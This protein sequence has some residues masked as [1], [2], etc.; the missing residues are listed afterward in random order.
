M[1]GF[2]GFDGGNELMLASFRPVTDGDLE[3][4]Y[5]LY[6]STRL[7]EMSVTGWSDD[8]VEEFL[9]MQFR[10]QH[11][12]YMQNYKG[13]SFDIILADGIPAG[14]LY[15]HRGEEGIRV[16]DISI[17]PEFRR[18]GIGGDIL[19]GLTQEA[20]A[21]GQM[22]SLHVEINNP[23]LEFYKSL[24]FRKKDLRGIYFYMEREVNRFSTGVV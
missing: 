11:I 8:Q 15:V 5:K 23:V 17:L 14:R 10:L 22:V 13:A 1:A 9:R 4:L 21:K 7:S 16:I 3:F 20:D 12:Q 18:K 24:G 19:R 2:P 6:A